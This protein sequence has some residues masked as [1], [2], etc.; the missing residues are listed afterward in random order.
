[1]L[2]LFAIL[3]ALCAALPAYA[4]DAST[5]YAELLGLR[6]ELL[7]IVTAQQQALDA[8]VL[9]LDGFDCELRAGPA[10]ALSNLYA[11]RMWDCIPK[12]SETS[13]RLVVKATLNPILA[14]RAR[15]KFET[16]PAAATDPAV[17]RTI[18]AWQV[19]TR[20][21]WAM[22]IFDGWMT[23]EVDNLDRRNGQPVTE[24]FLTG[25]LAGPTEALAQSLRSEPRAEEL[26]ARTGGIQLRRSE[27]LYAA[28]IAAGG[29]EGMAC[30]ASP[31]VPCAK[32]GFDVPRIPKA[33]GTCHVSAN[34]SATPLDLF[35]Q[36]DAERSMQKLAR[37]A[38][39]RAIMM[40]ELV[41]RRRG[42]G[43]FSGLMQTL[44][45]QL[46]DGM[47]VQFVGRIDRSLPAD[48][49]CLQSVAQLLPLLNRIEAE[50]HPEDGDPDLVARIAAA[51]EPTR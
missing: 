34:L 39:L 21:A 36:K 7:D 49:Q 23:L 32:A 45:Y 16:L 26:R 50:L 51:K 2:R 24:A 22:A 9:G 30:T 15:K 48:A 43:S 14:K 17:V 1:M 8:L 44:T 38:E 37:D 3:L 31:I 40:A 19:S 25:F 41:E 5:D 10:A 6:E 18:G 20:G 35:A 13:E 11:D 29:A 42:S 12:A 47:L 27:R 28:L 33:E 46:D 4:Q